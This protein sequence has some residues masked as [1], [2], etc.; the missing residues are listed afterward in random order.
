MIPTDNSAHLLGQ[1]NYGAV[2]QETRVVASDPPVLQ[3][4]AVKRIL[5]SSD[6]QSDEYNVEKKAFLVSEAI[7]ANKGMRILPKLHHSNF[8][9]TVGAEFAMDKY[10]DTADH[11]ISQ[12]GQNDFCI[13]YV[14]FQVLTRLWVLHSIG[15]Y[16]NDIFLRNVMVRTTTEQHPHSITEY[17]L[18]LGLKS[19]THFMIRDPA[20]EVVLIDCGLCSGMAVGVRHGVRMRQ[21]GDTKGRHPLQSSHAQR[22]PDLVDHCCLCMSIRSIVSKHTK[23]GCLSKAMKSLDAFS[24]FYKICI[25]KEMQDA[26]LFRQALGHPFFGT[27]ITRGLPS[28]ILNFSDVHVYYAEDGDECGKRSKLG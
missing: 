12:D 13:A 15:V 5:P 28:R 26:Q 20:Y 3:A 9:A 19:T 2:Y 24:Q 14:M 27:L 1:G 4:C 18:K 6:Y 17:V 16:H 7:H 8:C 11:W 21:F 10:D 23:R 22:R 25:E